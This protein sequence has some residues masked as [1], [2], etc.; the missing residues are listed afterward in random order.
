MLLIALPMKVMNNSN[1]V[2]RTEI[3]NFLFV[4]FTLQCNDKNFFR[5]VV[6]CEIHPVVTRQYLVVVV[7]VVA[8]FDEC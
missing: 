1:V 2:L 5:K 8:N 3:N 6:F 7:V 4:C